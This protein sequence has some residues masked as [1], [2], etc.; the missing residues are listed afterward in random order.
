MEATVHET[1]DMAPAVTGPQLIAM[2]VLT[3]SF[4]AAGV[5]IGALCGD[6]SMRP[7][8]QMEPTTLQSAHLRDLIVFRT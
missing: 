6:L 1:M 3:L 5:F 2:T 8:Q 4:L 7:S